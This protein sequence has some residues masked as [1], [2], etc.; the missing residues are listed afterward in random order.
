MLS[1][2]TMLLLVEDDVDA[3][4][5]GTDTEE[6]EEKE[7]LELG[8]ESG[9][10]GMSAGSTR[11]TFC[12]I[13]RGE[14]K[15]GVGR[16]ETEGDLTVEYLRPPL[17]DGWLGELSV[18]GASKEDIEPIEE[19]LPILARCVLGVT[20]VCGLDKDDDEGSGVSGIKRGD[21]FGGVCGVC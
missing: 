12:S 20:A 18:D 17:E 21:G 19:V 9:G 5:C 6:R 4:E 15:Q 2:G 13:C 16:C 14:E 8:G 7:T 3:D 10:S 11:A 1:S